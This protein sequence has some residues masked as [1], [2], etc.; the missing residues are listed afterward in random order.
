MRFCVQCGQRLPEQANFCTHCGTGVAR[1]QPGPAKAA[2]E[3]RASAFGGPATA[4]LT[5][6]E[7]TTQGDCP[8]LFGPPPPPPGAGPAPSAAG[9]R[10]VADTWAWALVAM[11]LVITFIGALFVTSVGVDGVPV[12]ELVA[13]LVLNSAAV[14]WDWRRLQAAGVERPPVWLG[15]FLVPAYLYR[16]AQLLGRNQLTLGLWAAALV[17]SMTPAVSNLAIDFAGN[18]MDAATVESQIANWARDDVGLGAVDVSCPGGIPAKRGET[19]TCVMSDGYGNSALV[20]VEVQNEAG[21]VVW[22]AR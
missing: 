9:V 18:K 15:L 8:S 5:R 10:P 6:P 22:Q 4:V 3:S 7:V 11:P 21:D 17:L 12:V 16:R 14:I 19:F 13:A 1:S 2:E 20:E